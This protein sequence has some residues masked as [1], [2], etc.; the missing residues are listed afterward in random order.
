MKIS[1]KRVEEEDNN[2]MNNTWTISNMDYERN[3]L[4][5][6]IYLSK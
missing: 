3:T 4:Y 2:N 6:R 1:V 5:L